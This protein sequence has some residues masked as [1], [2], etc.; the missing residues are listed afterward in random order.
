MESFVFAVNAVAPIILTVAVGYVLKKIGLMNASLAKSVNKLVFHVFLPVMLFL[1][2]YKIHDITQIELGYVGYV[3]IMLLAIFLIALPISM[4]TTK[5]SERRGVLWQAMFRSNFALIGIP[6]AV[7]LF[8]E[9]GGI[10]ASLLS[11][12]TVPALNILAVISLSV[13]RKDDGR[14]G[15]KNILLDIIKNP[16][17]EGVFLGIV[18][19]CVKALFVRYGIEFRLSDI[20]PVYTVLGY[21]S[22][23]ATP[24]ALLCLGAQFEFSAVKELRKEIFV[25]TLVRTAIVPILGIGT[26]VLLFRSSFSGA[27]FAAFIAIFATPVSVSSV[28]MTQEMGGDATLAG[29]FVVWTTV[30]SAFT[31]FTVSFLLKAIGI[32]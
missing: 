28:P 30:I 12:A 1:N 19:L 18:F 15:I 20:K 24:L 16:L 22:S 6:L 32:F 4:L 14:V 2:I 27:H 31:I 7:S 26:A 3:M 8:G 10:V 13:F 9:Q 25:G 21:L 5:Q 23:L 29:Q 11:A 17:I